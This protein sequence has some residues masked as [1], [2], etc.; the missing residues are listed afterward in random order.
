MR[1]LVLAMLSS[2]AIIDP[3]GTG[4]NPCSN[5]HLTTGRDPAT[6]QCESYGDECSPAAAGIHVAW[7]AC[8]GACDALAEHACLATAACH[9][10]YAGGAFS[11]CWDTL[12]TVS[13]DGSC[14]AL[15]DAWNCSEHDNCASVMVAGAFD[16]CIDEPR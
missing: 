13:H 11:A 8:T 7:P 1:L 5:D 14:T 10:A 12:T 6:G 15:G 3:G 2:C 16:H 4:A 9:A